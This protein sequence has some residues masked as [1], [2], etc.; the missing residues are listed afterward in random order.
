MLI[1][2]SMEDGKTIREPAAV[3]EPASGVSSGY[4]CKYEHFQPQLRLQEISL[5]PKAAHPPF[6]LNVDA[7]LSALDA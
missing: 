5:P 1:V 2:M 6:P 7:L 4:E 3:E